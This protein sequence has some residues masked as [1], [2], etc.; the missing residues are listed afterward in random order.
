MSE[1]STGRFPAGF[2]RLDIGARREALR[3]TFAFPD[4]EWDS[5]SCAPELFPL[6]DLMV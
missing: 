5:I 1:S 6:L 3:K 4:D 2:R